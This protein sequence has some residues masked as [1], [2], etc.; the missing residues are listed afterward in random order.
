MN[1]TEYKKELFKVFTKEVEGLSFDEKICFIERSIIKFYFEK[2]NEALRDCSNKRKPWT[3]EELEIILLEAPTTANCMK[4][5]RLFK[6]GYGSIAQIYRWAS[7]QNKELGDR[8][9]TFI[10]Q[11]KRVASRVGFRA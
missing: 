1:K 4:F 8:E 6:R 3:D 7:T 2:E 10:R 11:I 9:D 5:A